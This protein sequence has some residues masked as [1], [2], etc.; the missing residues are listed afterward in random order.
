M[1]M[2]IL[3]GVVPFIVYSWKNILDIIWSD[4]GFP[5]LWDMPK[6]KQLLICWSIGNCCMLFAAGYHNHILS[7]MHGMCLR[8]VEA[9]TKNNS[10]AGMG[11][12]NQIRVRDW[13][14]VF[15]LYHIYTLMTLKVIITRNH[16][17]IVKHKKTTC[18]TT[19]NLKGSPVGP[20]KQFTVNKPGDSPNKQLHFLSIHK[21]AQKTRSNSIWHHMTSYDIWY[22][23]CWFSAFSVPR[24]HQHSR[25]MN[26]SLVQ[27]ATWYH[28]LH[29]H[30]S[31]KARGLASWK[32]L[33]IWGQL[34]WQYE[35]SKYHISD[36]TS[37]ASIDLQ[38]TF[39]EDWFCKGLA[40]FN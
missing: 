30:T 4:F 21:W 38:L 8:K 9:W 22:S 15:V 3:F 35:N 10:V 18:P 33:G 2:Q 34:R 23:M 17:K 27:T 25:N 7:P 31:S 16:K 1:H 14:R 11:W 36:F 24:I 5:C 32:P 13:W 19:S 29:L 26:T 28:T 40:R 39:L 20:F 6:S 37:E 12:K